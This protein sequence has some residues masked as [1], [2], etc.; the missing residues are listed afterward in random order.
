MLTGDLLTSCAS[1][2]D[3]NTF[4]HKSFYEQNPQ[5]GQY[6]GNSEEGVFQELMEENLCSAP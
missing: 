6:A 3:T 1:Y 5:P 4:Y 2:T